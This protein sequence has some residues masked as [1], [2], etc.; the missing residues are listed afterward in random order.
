M[1]QLRS[2]IAFLMA[3][4]L[5][6]SLAPYSVKAADSAVITI[7]GTVQ[8]DRAFALLD[9]INE[10]RR[11]NKLQPL[12]M[13]QGMLDAAT[14]RSAELAVRFRAYRPNG[15]PFY[16]AYPMQGGYNATEITEANYSN[17]QLIQRYKDNYN[18]LS[19]EYKSAG[20]GIFNHNGKDYI[21]IFLSILDNTPAVQPENQTVTQ[22]IGIGGTVFTLSLLGSD[23]MEAGTQQELTVKQA[24]LDKKYY[25]AIWNNEGLRWSSSNPAV[26]TV[27]EGVIHALSAGT[28]EITVAAGASTAS[29]TVTVT[30]EAAHS[31]TMAY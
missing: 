5:F 14:L 19:A 2:T 16:T 20:I 6:L 24:N 8:Y 10:L 28:T 18:L 25:Y 4:C 22:E 31:H 12:V 13:D 23:A 1:K 7:D 11:E 3:L 21:L 27:H 9:A 26:A 15:E 29:F 17:E 30:G